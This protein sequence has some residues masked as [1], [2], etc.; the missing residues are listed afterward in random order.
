MIDFR[1]VFL[2]FYV[3]CCLETFKKGIIDQSPFEWSVYMSEI[4]NYGTTTTKLAQRGFRYLI[5]FVY[6]QK[7][8]WTSIHV[9]TCT[10]AILNP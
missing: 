5:Y 3:D 8:T 7:R 2:A 9:L 1:V 10:Y 4:C 6:S